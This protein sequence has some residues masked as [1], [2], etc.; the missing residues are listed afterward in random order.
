MFVVYMDKSDKAKAEAL[1]DLILA[2]IIEPMIGNKTTFMSDLL[3][4]GKKLMNNEF[5]G[6]FASDKIPV[7][8]NG[9]CIVNLDDSSQPGSHWVAIGF[10]DGKQYLYDSFGRHSDKIIRG[11]KYINTE[12]D[13]EQS[14]YETNC[15]ARSMSA[16]LILYLFGPE[17]F[18]W[19]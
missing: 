1:Y 3:K 2:D 4:C 8:K 9:Y 12:N 5:L 7:N 13:V 17:Y 14:T 16:I 18:I 19:L 15:G 6:V 10:I 11:G